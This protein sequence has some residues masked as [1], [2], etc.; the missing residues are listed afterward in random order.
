MN[1]NVT[2]FQD[3]TPCTLIHIYQRFDGVCYFHPQDN[4][5]YCVTPF[6]LVDIYQRFQRKMLRKFLLVL[7]G[8]T[9]PADS[10]V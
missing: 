7:I 2:V 9:S 10:D 4:L 8:D 6:R 5:L 1:I 3:V